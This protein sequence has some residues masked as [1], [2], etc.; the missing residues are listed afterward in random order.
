LR[1]IEFEN[2]HGVAFMGANFQSIACI[3]RVHI[4]SFRK[5]NHRFYTMR[6][7]IRAS[8]EMA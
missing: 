2:S 6:R 7:K 3:H 8:I 5:V 1:K 4:S